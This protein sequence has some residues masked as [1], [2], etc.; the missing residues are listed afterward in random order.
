[1]TIKA[2][3]AIQAN[4]RKNYGIA[5]RVFNGD[6]AVQTRIDGVFELYRFIGMGWQYVGIFLSLLDAE[7]AAEKNWG[8]S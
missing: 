8:S 6:Y 5:K 3:A 1:M 2:L 7:K 4:N